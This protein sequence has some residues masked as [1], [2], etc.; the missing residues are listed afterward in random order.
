MLVVFKAKWGDGS[1]ICVPCEGPKR[2]PKGFT[3]NQVIATAL[4]PRTLHLYG[5]PKEEHPEV[6]ATVRKALIKVIAAAEEEQQ[7]QHGAGAAATAAAGS[8]AGGAAA[9]PLPMGSARA[10]RAAD[11][12]WREESGF[13]QLSRE[14]ASRQS[15]SPAELGGRSR[16]LSGF[17]GDELE[18]A[19]ESRF[20]AVADFELQE[21]KRAP[22]VPFEVVGADGKVVLTNPL[23]W[24]KEHASRFRYMAMLA[25]RTLCIPATSAPS[26]RLFSVAGMVVTKKRNRLSDHAVTLLVWLHGAW[27]F[28]DAWAKTH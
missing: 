12:N 21:F 13:F 22:F 1:N 19:L 16:S 24:W 5:V 14:A 10:S 17:T 27:A 11:N 2:Q 23:A 28:L 26:E 3:T 7:R 6:W 9:A 25:R 8:A 4:D 15:A 18:A 20:G